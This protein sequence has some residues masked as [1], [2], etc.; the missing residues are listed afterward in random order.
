MRVAGNARR[1]QFIHRKN[2]NDNSTCD[3]CNENDSGDA[4][5]EQKDAL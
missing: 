3:I 5:H 4:Y 1:A 2:P